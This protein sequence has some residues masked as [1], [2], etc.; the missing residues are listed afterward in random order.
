VKVDSAML[1]D[2]P[3]FTWGTVTAMAQAGIRYF[4]AAPNFFD[5]I[6]T[7]M[8]EW[9]D[10]PFWATSPSGK[11]KVLVWIPWT[12]YAMSHV[13]KLGA[14]WVGSYQERLD[15]AKFPYDISYIRWSGHGDNAVP[16]PELSEFIRGWN[17]KY[18]WPRFEIS[19]TSDAFAAFEKKH[20]AEIPVRHGDLTPYWE[21]GAASSALETAMSRRAAERLVQAEAFSAMYAGGDG[22]KPASSARHGATS[23]STLSTRGARGLAS[24]IRRAR[25]PGI[26]GPSSATLP[27]RPI[28]FRSSCWKPC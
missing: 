14:E 1:S 20:G 11:E 12:G 19:S 27:S 16:D 25:S 26:S 15:A 22:P 5:R 6:G 13:M 8:V 9:Q 3:G 10:K 28:R 2:V 17:E 23:C 18:E 21:D 7:L 24:R 4:S